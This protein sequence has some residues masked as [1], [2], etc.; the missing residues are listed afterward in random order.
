MHF[1]IIITSQ[2]KEEPGTGTCQR[3]I[4]KNSADVLNKNSSSKVGIEGKKLQQRLTKIKRQISPGN[5]ALKPLQLKSGLRQEWSLSLSLLD[6]LLVVL[7]STI[8]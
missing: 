5:K 7:A 6:P 2:I 4:A 8:K 3:V 1:N